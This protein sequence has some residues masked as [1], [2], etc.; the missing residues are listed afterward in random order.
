[1]LILLYN[2][3]W[4]RPFDK[5]LEGCDAHGT[6]TLDRSLMPNAD[7]VVFHVPTMGDISRLRKTP[8]QEWIAWSM[9]SQ[10]YYPQ[11]LDPEFMRRFDRTMT[12]RLD[13]DIP[14][15]YLAPDMIAG[16]RNEPA[17]KTATALAAYF[18]SNSED[19][20][21]RCEY[22]KELMRHIEVD[23]YG[24]S[25]QNKKLAQDTGRETKLE[26]IARY[27]FTLAFENSLTPDYVSEKL[28]D[29]L[30]VGSIPV[31]LGAPNVDRFAPG[32]NCFINASRFA[33]PKE[34]ADHLHRLAADPRQYNSFLQ[35]KQKPFL[36]SFREVADIAKTSPFCRLCRL[37]HQRKERRSKAIVVPAQ[38]GTDV[39]IIAEPGGLS[40][41]DGAAEGFT[42]YLRAAATMVERIEPAASSKRRWGRGSLGIAV[43]FA[44]DGPNTWIADVGVR[45]VGYC[46]SWADPV[47]QSWIERASQLDL[48]ITPSEASHEVWRKSGFAEDRLRICPPGIDAGMFQPGAGALRLTTA[49][50]FDASAQRARF[51][52]IAD[53][54]PGSNALEN[55]MTLLRVWI[56]ATRPEDDAALIVK[57]SGREH[58]WQIRLM[59]DLQQIEK[60]IGKTREQAAPIFLYEALLSGEQMARLY[61][62]ATHYWTL[63]RGAAWDA[64]LV[65]AGA[66]GLHLIAP[67]HTFY[68]TFLDESIAT[69]IPGRESANSRSQTEQSVWE[70]D[71]QAAE[72]KLRQAIQTSALKSA[73]ERILHSF[74]WEVVGPQMVEIL[75]NL[76]PAPQRRWR[77]S[78]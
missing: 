72:E 74:A 75:R 49:Q 3:Q 30:I 19:L 69:L 35:W 5:E 34:L 24:R 47:P 48:V 52:H 73:R 27:K 26:T 13:S 59:R 43:Q 45:N 9:E 44:A 57:L 60:S 76:P 31:Y 20:S 18:V 36:G 33:S 62:L 61:G 21:G 56:A 4:D 6:V 28:F 42:E 2:T 55:L 39:T 8:G 46:Q 23:S 78:R 58:G 41:D 53:L 12:Y 40:A 14:V 22:V 64:A 32:E 71:E 65:R 66:C 70:P 37:L 1:M 15:P 7:A 10:L 25:L 67:G 51:L 63:S 77:W 29:P 54:T 17:E 50:A 11:L 38:L 68:T 16:L